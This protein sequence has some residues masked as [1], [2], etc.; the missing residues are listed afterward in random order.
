MYFSQK[1]LHPSVVIKFQHRQILNYRLDKWVGYKGWREKKEGSISPLKN[2]LFLRQ[3]LSCIGLSCLFTII[4]LNNSMRELLC[5]ALV[6]VAALDELQ[7]P[8]FD[9]KFFFICLLAGRKKTVG[10]SISL[11]REK[12]KFY[13]LARKPRWVFRQAKLIL[14]S[15]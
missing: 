2:L 12:A 14:V 5:D 7:L 11:D 9:L 10:I 15:T 8:N 6:I 13:H 1:K 4:R 3:S